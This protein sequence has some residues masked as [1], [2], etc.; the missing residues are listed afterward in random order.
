MTRPGAWRAFARLCAAA[1]CLAASAWAAQPAQRPEPDRLGGPIDLVDQDGRPFD[2]AGIG[3]GR[4][5]VFFGFTRC[6]STCPVAM[7]TAH[8][9]LS[10]RS[11]GAAPKVIFITLDPLADGP[12]QLRA[13][14]QAFDPRL[15]GL[16]GTPGQVARV[17]DRYGVGVDRGSNAL[18]HSAKWYLVDARG[19]V[20]RVFD[21]DTP[22][23]QLA[24]ALVR[25]TILAKDA[26]R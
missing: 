20:D 1:A 23:E 21:D 25:P 15:V 13:Y 3:A 22:A 9:V 10:R 5:L 18:G 12:A 24:A 14:L 4:A 19:R 8:E 2:L 7:A 16:T 17:A 11:M 26:S 6:G